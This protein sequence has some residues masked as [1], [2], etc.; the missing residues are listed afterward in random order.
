MGAFYKKTCPICNNKLTKERVN[1]VRRIECPNQCYGYFRFSS[2][3]EL[4]QVQVRVFGKSFDVYNVIQGNRKT[5]KQTSNITKEI[6]YWKEDERYLLKL[7][8]IDKNER[9]QWPK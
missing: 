1:S 8:T 9:L 6:N 3:D 4:Y 5:Y 7:L 2:Q